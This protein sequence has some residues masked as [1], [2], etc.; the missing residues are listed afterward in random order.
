MLSCLQHPASASC[1]G[2]LVSVFSGNLSLV[3]SL[4]ALWPELFRAQLCDQWQNTKFWWSWGWAQPFAFSADWCL[5]S[6]W[7]RLVVK[8]MLHPW[9]SSHHSLGE[10]HVNVSKG[11]DPNLREWS[12]SPARTRKI[13]SEPELTFLEFQS[14][15]NC[16]RTKGSWAWLMD[17]WIDWWVPPGQ[18][19][20][21]DHHNRY[22]L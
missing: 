13:Q 19:G 18:I 2:T 21:R 8:L 14:R 17:G 1:P 3:W 11:A 16:Q 15:E 5:R 12:Y 6:R 10:H 4:A 22:G 20:R 7:E 9:V